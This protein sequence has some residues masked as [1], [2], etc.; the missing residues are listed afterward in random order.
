MQKNTNE[1]MSTLKEKISFVMMIGAY[2]ARPSSSSA[3]TA[4]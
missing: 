2:P 1:E 3:A 4:A